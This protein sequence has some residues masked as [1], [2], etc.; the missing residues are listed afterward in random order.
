MSSLVVTSGAAARA[1]YQQSTGTAVVGGIQVFSFATYP[2]AAQQWTLDI[3]RSSVIHTATMTASFQAVIANHQLYADDT[4]N[5]AALAAT[6]NNISARTATTAKVTKTGTLT[7]LNGLAALVQEI[8]NR[9]DWEAG[10]LF[11]LV[12]RYI[13]GGNV[14]SWN[15]TAAQW[16][17]LT[18]VYSLPLVVSDVV[19]LR[20]TGQAAVAARETA[21]TA[22]TMRKVASAEVEL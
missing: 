10:N 18:V 11:T 21:N 9:D 8:V 7:E 6:S 17:T 2:Y 1:G 4:G 15:N 3:P 16:P 22:V 19:A 14:I 20:E 13:S 12:V 5:S